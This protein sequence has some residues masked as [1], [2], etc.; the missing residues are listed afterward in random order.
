MDHAFVGATVAVSSDTSVAD[1]LSLMDDSQLPL[2]CVFVV[3]R[4][5]LEGFFTERDLLSLV[6]A[7]RSLADLPIAEVMQRPVISVRRSELGDLSVP[8]QLLRQHAVDYLAVLGEGGELHGVIAQASLPAHLWEVVQAQRAELDHRQASEAALRKGDAQRRAL[9]NALPDLILR[10]SAEGVYLDRIMSANF[11]TC[12]GGDAI[13][14]KRLDQVLPTELATL[15]LRHIQRA[16]RTGDL[17]VYEQQIVV[18]DSLR[19]EE[20]RITPCGDGEVLVIVRDITDRKA[21]EATNRAIMGAI[22][23]LLIRIDRWGQYLDLLGGD[24]VKKVLLP[25]D[26]QP[27]HTV[28]D[29]LPTPLAEQKI[30]A[31]QQALD[32]GLVQAYEQQIEIDGERRWEEV[33]VSPVGDDEVLMMIRDISDR[34]QAELA[35]CESEATNRALLEAIPDLLVRVSAEGEYLDFIGP[36]RS[37]NLLDPKV[38]VPGGSISALLPPAAAQAQMAVLRRAL[39]TRQLQVYEQ[40][41]Q[42]GDRIQYE[43]VRAICLGDEEVLLIIRDISDRKRAEVALQEFNQVLEA[44]VNERTAALRESEERWQL[45]IQGSNASL[46]DWNVKTNQVFRTRRWYDLRGLPEG[47]PSDTLEAWSEVI[48]PEDRDRVLAAMADHLAQK[49]AFYQQE[50]RLRRQDGGYVWILDRGQAVW[51]EDGSPVRMIGSEMNITQRKEAELEAQRL[52]EQL[53]FVLSSNPAAIFTCSPAGV[54]APTFVSDNI[55]NLSG[56][57]QEEFLADPNF[58]ASHLHPQDAPRLFAELPALFERGQHIHEYRFLH[59]AGHYMWVRN[60]LRLIRDAQGNPLEIVGY[61]ADIGDRKQ[62]ENQLRS[63]EAALTEAQHMVHLGSWELDTLTHDLTWSEEMFRIFGLDPRQPEPAYVE[64]LKSIHPEDRDRLEHHLA[65]AMEQGI[66]YQIELRIFRADGSTGYLESRGEAKW[67]DQGQISK[68]FGTALDITE[69]KQAEVQLQR[70]N[71]RLSLTNAELDRATR[72]KDEFLANMSHELRTPLNA[73]LGMAEGLKEQ[74]FG[75]I[76]D[77]QSHALETIERSGTHLLELIDDILDLSKIEADKLELDIASV[78]VH[79]L[80][81]TSLS[82]VRQMALSKSI[83]LRFEPLQ[84]I[85]ELAMDERRMRQVLINLLS[86]AV[87]FTPAGGQV[88]LRV[89][90]ESRH[91]RN[92]LSLSVIDT[93]IGIAPDNMA[94]LFQPFVQIDSSL[95]RQYTGTGLGLALVRKIAELHGGTV[96][97]TST[98]GQGSCFTVRLPWAAALNASDT[99]LPMGE[100][101]A[102]AEGAIAPCPPGQ[103]LDA[104]L[105]PGD[106]ASLA[107]MPIATSPAGADRQRATPLILLVEDNATT[108]ATISSFLTASGYR[109]I[110][111]KNG[112]DAI[113]LTRTHT[114]DLILMDIQMPGTDGLE[115]LRQIRRDGRFADLPVIAITALAMAGDRDRCLAAGAS[116]YLTKPVKM[117][118]LKLSIQQLLESGWMSARP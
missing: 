24:S 115:A 67:N 76:N 118:K 22:P 106:P 102:A 54:C 92:F 28:Y 25:T 79:H 112:Q 80:C 59:R 37:F 73:I 64:H 47:Q 110:Y 18:H 30:W 117:R 4:G 3:D 35:L 17:Q 75:Y 108:V 113:E 78:S 34:K 91:D 114:P 21:L 86:N 74:V 104:A 53:E 68:I 6:A 33:R 1:V 52:R 20:I 27:V 29:V 116:Q 19:I 81:E 12:C 50:Y 31:A 48:H 63:S 5:H 40:E 16:L 9:I 41:I 14:G 69:R 70:M 82:F 90:V 93:G 105:C 85:P 84:L 66:P 57:T 62:I 100:N 44:K 32:T 56:Y 58:W 101:S 45:A 95:S 7:G 83:G 42:V 107:S 11:H 26:N 72:L 46:W 38:V 61:F 88:T 111:A 36:D 51:D 43:E 49:T 60:E 97:V 94:K 77:R 2:P 23:D 10:T 99:D 55:V 87:K 98:V 96:A 71:E 103:S 13:V 8:V 89:Q 109:L 39:E 15:R 65:Q